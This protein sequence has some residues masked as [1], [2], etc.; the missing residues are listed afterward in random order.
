MK[1][2]LLPLIALLS[3]PISSKAELDPNIHKLCLPATDYAGCIEFQTKNKKTKVIQN[4]TSINDVVRGKWEYRDYE[5]KASGKTIFK[6]SL[7]S[8]NKINLSF[9]YSGFQNGT[10]SVRNHPRWGKDIY[11]KIEKG[12]I[13]SID[14]YSYD[15][16]Y[17]LVRFDDGDVKRWKYVGASDLSSDVIFIS[18]EKKFLE[19]LTNSNKIYITVNLYQDGQNT[20]VFD[21]KGLR[22]EFI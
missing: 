20:F 4:E 15:N 7:L 9:P 13:L 1:R 2:L 12:Q 5:D 17:F 21:S 10:L 19:K 16:K 22:K 11:L 18:N 14:G 8:V 6:A 3:L